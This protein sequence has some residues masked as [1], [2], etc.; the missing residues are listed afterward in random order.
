MALEKGYQ[1]QSLR[2]TG[3]KLINLSL[4]KRGKIIYLQL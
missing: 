2:Q 3:G 4:G 1:S